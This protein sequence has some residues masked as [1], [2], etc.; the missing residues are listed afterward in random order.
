MFPRWNVFEMLVE[1]VHY[2]FI[3]N[4]RG[5]Y[6]SFFFR[7]SDNLAMWAKKF[8][9]VVKKTDGSFKLH[10]TNLDKSFEEK[11]FFCQI[12]LIFQLFALLIK[13]CG[14]W[15]SNVSEVLSE[16]R[17]PCLQERFEK[18]NFLPKKRF[19]IIFIW[20]WLKKLQTFAK[21]WSDLS[22]LISKFSVEE[23]LPEKVIIFHTAFGIWAK[24]FGFFV[25]TFR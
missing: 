4:I 2:V 8:W 3:G 11:S 18:K 17:F 9:K 7:L 19:S 14:T 24:S 12:F 13:T 21:K 25:T 1:T 23:H 6:F 20:F 22:N 5:Y 16:L 10:F 15:G